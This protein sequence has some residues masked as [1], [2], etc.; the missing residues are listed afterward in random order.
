METPGITLQREKMGQQTGMLVQNFYSG[1]RIGEH[2]VDHCCLR[3][4]LSGV[5]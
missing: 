2:L 4:L 5:F 1:C 3:P